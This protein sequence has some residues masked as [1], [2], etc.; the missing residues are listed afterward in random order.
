[1]TQRKTHDGATDVRVAGADTDQVRSNCRTKCLIPSERFG[2]AQEVNASKGTHQSDD[3]G[4][5]TATKVT[6]SGCRTQCGSRPVRNQKSR[7]INRLQPTPQKGGGDKPTRPSHQRGTSCPA[8]AGIN[9]ATRAHRTNC[10]AGVSPAAS[11]KPAASRDPGHNAAG[12]TGYARAN[13]LIRTRAAE[14]ANANRAAGSGTATPK[15]GQQP[16]RGATHKRRRRTDRRC[17]NED[18]SH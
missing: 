8:R 6:G 3:A 4:K 5:R 16:P 14:L 10:S 1:M 18:C 9:R 12:T 13:A 2:S 7:T 15:L 17:S 11:L